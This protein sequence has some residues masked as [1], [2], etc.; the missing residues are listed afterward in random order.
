MFEILHY[1]RP[2][3]YF[4]SGQLRSDQTCRYR[5]HVPSPALSTF[6]T[7]SSTV[8]E[9][10]QGL[11][12][13]EGH[14]H[15]TPINE[16]LYLE[17][18]AHCSSTVVCRGNRNDTNKPRN[19]SVDF[20]TPVEADKLLHHQPRKLERHLE[21]LPVTKRRSLELP[22][23]TVSAAVKSPT[24]ESI[25]LIKP[26]S[27]TIK[28]FSQASDARMTKAFEAYPSIDS[29]GSPGSPPKRPCLH[30]HRLASPR[31]GVGW[32]GH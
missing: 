9:T 5:S 2:L 4:G 14:W 7:F 11:E 10:L 30:V 8:P 19:P 21:A 20:Q 31:R 6:C 13:S 26:Y 12:G 32:R 25:L 18:V 22:D 17:P 24:L 29:P 15:E 28:A 3:V 1:C 23:E 16:V 27:C